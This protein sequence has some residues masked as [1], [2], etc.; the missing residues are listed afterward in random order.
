MPTAGLAAHRGA[1][2]SHP[3]NTIAALREAVRL[4]AA[5]I[6]FDVRGTADHKLAV[7]HDA[8]VN[9]TTNGK[10]RVQEMSL[11]K[12]HALD[13][14]AWKDAAF[15]G[16]PVPTL[17]EALAVLPRDLWLNVNIKGEPWVAVASAQVL[18]EV[19]RLGQSFLA[20]DE[21]GARAAVEAVPEVAFCLLE[22]KANREGYIRA[23][24]QFI[25]LHK[26]RGTPQP[27]QIERLHNAGI[28]INFCCT[29]TA[30]KAEKLQH[31]GIDFPLVDS[32]R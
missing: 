32:F 7:I 19:G 13:A 20:V 3:E 1:A 2:D 24:A 30:K 28:R 29:D 9:R 25:Q 11:A 6:E 15:T 8:T 18:A 31:L 26:R 10:G 12:L 5:Q 14:G 4:G 23:S 21:K 17:R 22:R 16:E 27:E